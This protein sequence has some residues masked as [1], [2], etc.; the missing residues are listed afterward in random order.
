MQTLNALET[1]HKTLM[2]TGASGFVG[3]HLANALGHKFKLVGIDRNA[4]RLDN[5]LPIA[6]HRKLDITYKSS[7]EEVIR[8]LRPDFIIHL[9]AETTGWFENPYAVFEVNLTGSLNLY[10]SVL[11]LSRQVDYRPKIIHV[12]T[13]EAYGSGATSRPIVEETRLSPI[14]HYAASKASA[15]MVSF[16]YARS[17]G[18]NI[19][20]VRPFTHT[21]PGQKVG[22]FVPD[23]ISQVAQA[24]KGLIDDTLMVG[25]VDAVRDYLDVRDVIRAYELLLD[26]PTTPGSVYNICS[27]VGIKIGDLLNMIVSLSRK[28]L[29]VKQDPKRLRPSDTPI[30]VGDNAKLTRAT[31]WRPTYPIEQ[32]IQETLDYWRSNTQF[33]EE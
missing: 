32:T 29:A 3:R 5:K 7:V 20:T 17:H 16:D 10:E 13:S 24:E 28:P 2:I 23:M 27:G 31:G 19:V 1:S 18:L 22:F 12:S 15:D 25:N 26:A 33:L 4:S 30:F 11:A 6:D 14:N 9:A 21:G 8:E